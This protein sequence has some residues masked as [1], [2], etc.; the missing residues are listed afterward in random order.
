[1]AFSFNPSTKSSASKLIAIGP[2]SYDTISANDIH[3]LKRQPRA[4]IGN[5]KR[6]FLGSG[7]AVPGP[8][9]YSA[10]LKMTEPRNNSRERNAPRAII[11]NRYPSVD[12][13]L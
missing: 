11:A 13:E 2:Q 3:V 1:M 5:T 9:Q 8:D 7:K 6:L 10:H 12:V 4:T